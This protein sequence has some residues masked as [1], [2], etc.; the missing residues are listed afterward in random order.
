MGY[1]MNPLVTILLGVV[2]LKEGLDRLQ[3]FA[4]GLAAVGVAWMVVANPKNLTTAAAALFDLEALGLT[5]K[6]ERSS[7]TFRGLSHREWGDATKAQAFLF[8]TPSPSMVND[9]KGVDFV[10]DPKLPL[11]K[12]VG[13]QLA[14]FAAVLAAYNTGAPPAARVTLAGVPA[15]ADV[16]KSGVGAFL[17]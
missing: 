7:E 16:E 5:M 6:L 9:T 2:F 17:R 14:S 12:R 8:E 15:M 10:N 13:V 11:A 1:F 4:V 3:A